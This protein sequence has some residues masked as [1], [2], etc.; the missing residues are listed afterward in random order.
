MIQ[1]TLYHQETLSLNFSAWPPFK[2][3]TGGLPTQ[4]RN[5]NEKG[6]GTRYAL[7]LNDHFYPEEI[8]W[9]DQC[10]WSTCDAKQMLTADISLAKILG[11][12]LLGKEGRAFELTNKKSEWSQLIHD[13]LTITGER[14]YTR[15]NITIE[16]R[17]RLTGIESAISG[18]MFLSAKQNYN[19]LPEHFI[20]KSLTELFFSNKTSYSNNND[21]PSEEINREKPE[22]GISTIIIETIELEKTRKR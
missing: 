7:I 2:F 14:T 15:N 18:M 4:L 19:T 22:G 13:L 6:K 8:T 12:M 1:R 9:A 17:N 3:I 20:N 5:I 11:N 10:P 21:V 16:N